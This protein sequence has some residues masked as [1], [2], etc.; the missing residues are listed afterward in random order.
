M[1]DRYDERYR[2]GSYDRQRHEGRDDRGLMDRAGDEVRSWFGDD[3]AA[4]RRDRDERRDRE[5]YRGRGR[6]EEHGRYE[7]GYATGG[8]PSWARRGGYG[9]DESRRQVSGSW[10]PEEDWRGGYSA[11]EPYLGGST[12]G[13]DR[14]W[15]DTFGGPSS[16]RS[17]RTERYGGSY[18]GG[19]E[20]GSRAYGEHGGDWSTRQGPYAARGPTGYPRSADRIREDDCDRLADVPLIDATEIEVSVSHGEVTLSGSVRERADKRRAEDVIERLSGV[21][22][23]HNSLRVNRGESAHPGSVLGLGANTTAS[24]AG[25]SEI[26][27]TTSTG[28]SSDFGT[29]K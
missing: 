2:G 14:G 21:R 6:D 15:S 17:Y 13:A 5:M 3:D 4:R 7:R 22:E 27:G 25:Q 19:P 10:G 24:P 23:V 12:T 29:R 28:R 9:P 16:V 20:H 8:D 1:A 26:R 18:A 11:G